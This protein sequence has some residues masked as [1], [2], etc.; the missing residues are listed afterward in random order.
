MK[1]LLLVGL[2]LLLIGSVANAGEIVT[3]DATGT[4]GI[5]TLDHSSRTALTQNTNPTALT[6]SMYACGNAKYSY[7]TEGWSL[8]RMSL[9]WEFGIVDPFEVQ[10]VQWGLRRYAC[11]DSILPYGT[12]Q[13]PCNPLNDPFVV[14]VN[15][16]SIPDTA[17]TLTFAGMGAPF[18]SVPVTITEAMNPITP[19]TGTP[20]TT[21]FPPGACID[22]EIDGINYDLVVA[23]HNRSTELDLFPSA[24]YFTSANALGETA[25]SYVAFVD[26]GA[27]EP[28]TPFALGGATT[29]H[30]VLVVNGDLCAPPPPVTGACCNLLTGDCTITEQVPCVAPFTW[31]G[32]D[33]PCNVQTCPI[34]VPTQSKSWGQVK[35][36]YR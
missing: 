24:R 5:L 12:V 34:P 21:V 15:L 18:A 31:L 28:I 19:V 4:P 2:G 29:Q 20:I 11:Y 36:L 25:P 16:Y 10:N 30:L 33:I 14:D 3:D 1:S 6:T 35:S 23:F 13:I 22:P 8:R 7:V 17:L 26:C 27:P 32:A 9:A